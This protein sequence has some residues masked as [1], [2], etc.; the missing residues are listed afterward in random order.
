MHTLIKKKE[1]MLSFFS[2]YLTSYALSN[3][4]N[5]FNV[6]KIPTQFINWSS[7]L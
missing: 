6:A 1:F 2:L 3:F 7:K 4:Y 5:S